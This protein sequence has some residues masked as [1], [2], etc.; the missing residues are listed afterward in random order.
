MPSKDLAEWHS[1]RKKLTSWR[2]EAYLR[3][4]GP[5]GAWLV[6][7]DEEAFLWLARLG[8]GA[9]EDARS[10]VATPQERGIPREVDVRVDVDE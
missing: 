1:G 8:R 7:E 10:G 9:G 6:V 2:Q 3:T 5:P 4:N